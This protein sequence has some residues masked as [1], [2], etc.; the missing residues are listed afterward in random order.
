MACTT[1]VLNLFFF[2]FLLS[3]M[4]QTASK[5][6]KKVCIVGTGVSGCSAA[7]IL[8]E[9][10]V[11]VSMY[12]AGFRPGGRCNTR[13]HKHHGETYEFDHGAQYISP[14]TQVFKEAVS[15]WKDSGVVDRWDFSHAT[16]DCNGEK[17]KIHLDVKEEVFVGVPGM[18]SICNHM[19]ANDRITT[20]FGK[21]VELKRSSSGGWNVHLKSTEEVLDSDFDFVLTSDRSGREQMIEIDQDG[22]SSAVK[23]SSPA[24]VVM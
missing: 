14:K 5:A 4:I 1:Q 17:S 22:K 16:I 19:I 9:G 21:D 3:Q 15:S 10:G 23:L 6:F 11:N 24:I 13:L 12:D 18:S 8:A 20:N 7:R 2:F